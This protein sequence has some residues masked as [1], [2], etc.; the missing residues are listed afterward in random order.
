MPTPLVDVTLQCGECHAMLPSSRALYDED[1]FDALH[2]GIDLPAKC[3]SCGELVS[4][5]DLRVRPI[6]PGE[7]SVFDSDQPG[8]SA[9]DEELTVAAVVEPRQLTAGDVAA[10]LVVGT[11]VFWIV[12]M[13]M[14]GLS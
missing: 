2:V 7:L 8:D 1:R 5:I 9:D 13:A 6:R 12:A 3:P 4:S 10:V 11:V 14:G